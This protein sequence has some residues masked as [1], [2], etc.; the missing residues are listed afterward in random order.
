MADSTEQRISE[1]EDAISAGTMSAAQVFTQI[2]QLIALSPAAAGPQ[3][4]VG[5]GGGIAE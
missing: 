3:G 1:I 5:D 2:R 4:V